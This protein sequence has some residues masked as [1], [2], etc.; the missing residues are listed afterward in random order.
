MQETPEELLYGCLKDHF[1]DNT[2]KALRGGRAGAESQSY[3]VMKNQMSIR[4]CVDRFTA[5]ACARVSFACGL[6]KS[7]YLHCRAPFM[8]SGGLVFECTLRPFRP[9]TSSFAFT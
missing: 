7:G 9:G 1:A 4:A 3:D 2:A 5:D 8:S 6:E